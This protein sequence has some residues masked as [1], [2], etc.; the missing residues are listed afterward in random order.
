LAVSTRAAAVFE[1][2]RL[3]FAFR[4]RVLSS[5]RWEPKRTHG[6]KYFECRDC[7]KRY[8]AD[9]PPEGD[10]RVFVPG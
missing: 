5:H 6:E 2:K 10:H 1:M 4:C 8:F 7:K 9:E 3:W